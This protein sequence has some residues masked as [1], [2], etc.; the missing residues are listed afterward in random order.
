MRLNFY[1]NGSAF[2]PANGNSGAYFTSG[3]ALYLI[4]CGSLAFRYLAEHVG[5]DQWRQVYVLITHLHAD[6]AGSLATLISYYKYKRGLLVTVIHPEESI[7]ELLSLQGIDRDEYVYERKLKENPGGLAAVPVPVH[8]V[9]NMKCYGLLLSDAGGQQFYSGDSAAV[10]AEILAAFLNGEIERIYQD[11][12]VH[13]A[14]SPGHCYYRTL[15]Q[16][17]PERKRKQVYCIHLEADSE[18]ILR[19]AG[20]SIAGREEA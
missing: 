8:H 10:P 11:T 17:I 4:D 2:N 14:A 20:F 1:G 13:Q 6:H 12:S 5:L 7:V 18:P 3:D 9:D 16:L 15:E 19:A